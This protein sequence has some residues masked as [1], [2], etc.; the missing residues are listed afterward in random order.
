MALDSVANQTY[1]Q[2]E[3]IIIDGKS[4][5][6][7]LEVVSRY[8]HISRVV[9]EKDDG[10]YD[11]LNKGIALATGD[12]V[13]VLHSDDYFTEATSIE[14]IVARFKS[15]KSEVV[16]GDVQY[17]DPMNLNKI[18]R[19]YSSA[20]WNPNRFDR[21]FMPAH[22]SVYIKR[23]HYQNLGLYKTDYKIA[24]DFE[25]LV[26][27]LHKHNLSYSYC[28]F[29]VVTMRTGGISTKNFKNRYRQNMEIIRACKE[30]GIR[31]SM[32]KLALK[33]IPKLL[34]LRY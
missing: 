23:Q 1:Q 15:G 2:I 19:Y 12:I 27:Y 5:D 3:H 29:S 9:S 32:I 34:E 6:N 24:A 28:P 7:T 10:L 21:G 30:N 14:K 8:P 31:T 16:F 33:V 4:T 26:R 20:K 22:P 25:L 13:G 17:V 18:V 11:A